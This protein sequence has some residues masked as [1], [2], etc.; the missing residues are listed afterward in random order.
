[1][2]A[3]VLR[4]SI[5]AVSG[6]LSPE[7]GGPGVFPQINE[8][9]VRQPRHAM[10][11]LQ[12]AYHASPLKRLRNRRTV[13]TF[14]QRSLIDPMVDVFN[15]PSLDMSCERREASVVPTQAFAL[16]NGQFVHDM[17]LALAARVAREAGTVEARVDRAFRLVHGRA[18]VAAERELAL[19]HVARQTRYHQA[20]PPAPKVEPKPVVHTIT[21]E[22]TGEKSSFVQLD[23]PAKYE[24][25]LAPRDVDP[26]T[27]ALADL[28]L[29]LMNSNEFVYVY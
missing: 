10:G 27:R 23:D 3:E 25:N 29:V 28:A 14:Q 2:E 7:A 9:V 8:D 21:S 16:L 26:E 17:A 6:E 20:T 19:A 13:Y 22:L 18:P 15:G 1:V 11:S 4:D 5:L 24:E 12:P